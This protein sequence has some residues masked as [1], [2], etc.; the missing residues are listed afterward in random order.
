MHLLTLLPWTVRITMIAVCCPPVFFRKK[1][2]LLPILGSDPFLC[3]AGAGYISIRGLLQLLFRYLGFSAGE[4]I[5]AFILCVLV[6]RPYPAP[7]HLVTSPK[8]IQVLPQIAVPYRLAGSCAP[9]A[10]LPPV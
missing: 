4:R 6:V 10:A 5:H 1:V 9:V 8:V 7:P 3:G 2:F